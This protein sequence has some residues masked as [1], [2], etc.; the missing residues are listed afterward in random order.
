MTMPFKRRVDKSRD[1]TITPEMV[2]IF[3]RMKRANGK[4]YDDL[5]GTLWDLYMAALA[6]RVRPWQW[7]VVQSPREAEEEGERPAALELW[8]ALNQA[9]RETRALRNGGLPST[10]A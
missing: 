2:S 6:P 1:P 8:H 5:H 3:E 9:S 7:P 10:T 4:R